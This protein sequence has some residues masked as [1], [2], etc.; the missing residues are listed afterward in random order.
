MLRVDVRE[1]GDDR[2][3]AS[4]WTADVSA[5]GVSLRGARQLT[6]GQIV[7]MSLS[8]PGLLEPM[9][10]L[11]DVVWTQRTLAV[12][13]GVGV[14]VWSTL[15]RERLAHLAELATR[16]KAHRVRPY[17]VVLMETDPLAALTHR[18]A[19]EELHP[20]SGA[21]LELVLT[22][23][24]DET[25]AQVEAAPAD[26]VILGLHPKY[27]DS[28]EALSFVRD[29]AA[30]SGSVVVAL[31]SADDADLVRHASLVADVTFM[32]P[33]PIARIIDTIGHLLNRRAEKHENVAYV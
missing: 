3:L 7:R 26:M 9:D 33:V 18:I 21:H 20:V 10:V 6:R 11:G 22:R 17:R 32:K 29:N 23:G 15:D 12:A 4:A 27:R 19:L 30:L 2:A 25:R 5:G 13:G 24:W 16:P 1:G 8:F 31:A 28:R 14:R